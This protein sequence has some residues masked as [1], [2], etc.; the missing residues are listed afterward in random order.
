MLCN[1]VMIVAENAAYIVPIRKRLLANCPNPQS[2][3]NHP[4]PGAPCTPKNPS[5]AQRLLC[6][7]IWLDL[8]PNF[9]NYALWL[10]WRCPDILWYYWIPA[11]KLLV[12]ISWQIIQLFKIFLLGNITCKISMPILTCKNHTKR[13]HGGPNSTIFL[14][15]SF[16]W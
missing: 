5:W 14:I 7:T 16:S 10:V 1:K 11:L 15:F 4:A 6:P 12:F 8:L 2:P 3:A 9:S 13:G